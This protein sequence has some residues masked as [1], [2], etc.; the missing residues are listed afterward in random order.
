MK[1]ILRLMI[2]V[3]FSIQAQAQEKTFLKSIDKKLWI[4]FRWTS[5]SLG[6]R[7]YDRLSINIDG[8]INNV[9]YPLELQFDTGASSS[10]LYGNTLKS[11][12]KVQPSLAAQWPELKSDTV[13]QWTQINVELSMPLTGSRVSKAYVMNRYGQT[14]SAEEFKEGKPIHIGSWGLDACLGKIVLLDFRN[15]RIA[16]LDQSVNEKL[17][18]FVLFKLEKNRIKVPLTINGKE[19]YFLYDS[20]ASLFPIMTVKKGWD[21]IN[22]VATSDT[23]KG[24]STWGKYYDVYGAPLAAKAYLG[25]TPLSSKTIY[26]HPDPDKYHE[27]IF[28]EAGVVGSIGNSYFFDQILVID[29]RT[30]RFGVVKK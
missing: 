23:I 27:P 26:Y 6:G 30:N 12:V 28:D 19:F 20:G 21:S 8:K 2:F 15:Q 13:N 16:F 29:F 4:P 18:S 24:V 7:F 11:L 1:K 22:P 3:F 17:V 5:D 25:D 14:V 10:I 9:P